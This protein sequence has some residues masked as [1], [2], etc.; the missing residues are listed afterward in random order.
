VTWARLRDSLPRCSF[1]WPGADSFWRAYLT[2]ESRVSFTNITATLCGLLAEG[3]P[4]HVVRGAVA[5]DPALVGGNASEWALPIAVTV[6]AQQRLLPVTDSLLARFPCAATLP[7]L[8]DLRRASWASNETAAWEWAFDELLPNA[9]RSV[10]FNLYHYMPWIITDPQSNA[11]L[12]NVDFAVQQNAF[13][14]NFRTTGNPGKAGWRVAWDRVNV[15]SPPSALYLTPLLL[16]MLH[17]SST[18]MLPR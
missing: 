12:A 4:S 2:G 11:T 10:A 1:D 17:L 3:D 6:A 9:S 8:T 13:I 16:A 5:Y 7:I 18:Y 14:L 15:G